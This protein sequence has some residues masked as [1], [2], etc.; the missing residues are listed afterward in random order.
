RECRRRGLVHSD[1]DRELPV[2]GGHSRQHTLR[3]QREAGRQVTAL[4]HRPVIVLLAA[5]SGLERC[6]IV[7]ALRRR[8]QG[9]RRPRPSWARSVPIRSASDGLLLFG[10][11]WSERCWGGRRPRRTP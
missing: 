9:L 4:L 3:A 10:S 8:R 7:L 5:T 11:S 2:L 1:P 6:V